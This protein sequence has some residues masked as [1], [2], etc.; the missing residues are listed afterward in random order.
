MLSMYL[1]RAVLTACVMAVL[2]LTQATQAGWWHHHGSYGSAGSYVGY[3]SAGSYGSYGSAGSAG[4]YGSYGSAGS[5]GH[6]T[7]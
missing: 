7:M 4:S 6:V 2:G 3:A 1:F 5:W